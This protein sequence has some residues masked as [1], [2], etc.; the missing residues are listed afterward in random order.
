MCGTI[1]LNR[2]GWP[3]DLN[4]A[5]EKKLKVGNIHFAKDGNM[6]TT[7]WKDKRP[8]TVLSTNTQPEMGSVDRKAPKGKKKVAVPEPVLNYNN[9]MGGVDLA[10][11]LH[12]YDPV[13]RPSIK[14]WWYI[15]WW[16]LQTAMVNSFLIF[17]SSNS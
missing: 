8:V 16:L 5:W 10:N 14:W 2:C 6:G 1:H 12:S 15:C 13:G 17:K 7:S 3:K 9:S 4:G 11:Q